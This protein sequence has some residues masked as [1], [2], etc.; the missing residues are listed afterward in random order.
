M[1]LI[2]VFGISCF[3]VGFSL[4]HLIHLIID[5]KNNRY[6]NNY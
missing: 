1:L 2:V 3:A 5:I 6:K 4:A